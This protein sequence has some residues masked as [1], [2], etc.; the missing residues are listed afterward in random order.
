VRAFG[1][2]LDSWKIK[3]YKK[4]IT[5]FEALKNQLNGPFYTIFT[6]FDESYKID[7]S[8]LQA[9]L[10]FL[11][12]R[13]ARR[14]YAMA[15]N[16]RYSQ[17]SENEIKELNAFCSK[18]LKNLNPNNIVIVGDP[19]HGSTMQSLE[20][21]KHAKD[22]GADMISL[23]V[24]EKYFNDDQILEHFHIIGSKADF[25]L[26]VHEMPFLSGADGSQMHWPVSLIE[27]LTEVQEIVALK[28][29]AKDPEIAKAA[30]KLEPDIK[31]ILAGG[32]KR[33]F[34]EYY[35]EHN[36]KAWLNGISIIDP[37]I[38][39]QYYTALENGDSK[40]IDFV[41]NE[42]EA[43]FF[44]GVAKKYGW[45]RVNKALLEAAGFMHRRDRMPLKH[46]SDTEYLDVLSTYKNI[47]LTWDQY[48][49][50]K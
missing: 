15:Y 13:G 17:L 5:M 22:H 19:I 44:D 34:N 3:V 28:E 50:S 14:F 47:K 48:K 18:V 40:F 30:F 16:S 36:A 20:Y 29:D 2:R 1:K 42:L 9:Y 25:P 26:L 39:E 27:R 46:L 37:A 6:P 7:Y 10:E 11:Y 38:S 43:P 45:H 49:G 41:C 8:A 33:R 21:A 35:H 32:G 24:R 12:E 4:V 31:V 23:L